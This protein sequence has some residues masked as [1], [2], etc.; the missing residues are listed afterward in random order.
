MLDDLAVYKEVRVDFIDGR[1][2]DVI[3][4]LTLENGSCEGEEELA[5]VDAVSSPDC[6]LVE[7]VVVLGVVEEIEEQLGFI[8]LCCVVWGEWDASRE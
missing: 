2:N 8:P 3:E 6:G 7:G 1:Q 4:V 5:L